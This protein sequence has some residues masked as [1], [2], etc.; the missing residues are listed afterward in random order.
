[1][2]SRIDNRGQFSIIAAL[3]V[4]IVLIGTLIAVYAMIRY[5]SSQNQSPQTLTATDE[6][7]LAI[8]KALGFTVGYYGSMLQVTGNQTYAEANA[9]AYMN[10]A[11]RYIESMNPSWG[12]SISMTSLDLRTD[13]FTNP[14]ISEG[15]ISVSYDLA[16]LGIYGINYT[17]SCSLAVQIFK[18]P[19]NNQVC[20]NVTQDSN[21]PLTS[22]GQQNFAFYEYNYVTSNWQLVNPS[23]TPIIFTNGTYLINTPPGIENSA[24]MVQVTDSR[25]IMVEA[26]S[27]NSFNLNFAFGSQSI[28]Q[29]SPIIVQLLQNGT[30]QTF[31]QDLVNTTQILPIPPIPVKSINLCQTGATTD[32]PFQ[33]EDWSSGYMIPLG[34]T[35]CYTIFSN[36]QM[37]VFEVTPSTSQLTLWWNGS[38]T[39]IQPSAAYTDKYFTGDNPGAGTLSNG[40]VTLNVYYG[41]G[42]FDIQTIAGSVTSTA[43]F[44]RINKDASNYGSGP[45][46]IIQYGV[47]RDIVQEEAEWSGGISGCPNVYS[48]IVITLPANANYFTYQLRTIFISSTIAR[49]VTDL[50]P[51]QLATTATQVQPMTENGT[52][53]GIPIVSSSYAYFTNSTGNAHQ[54]SEL[55]NSGLQGAGI[56]FTSSENQQ[57]YAFDS[58]TNP[59]AYTGALYVTN[60]PTIE[61]DP[62]T[63][64]GSASFTSAKDITWYG[65]VATFNG[66]NPIYATTGNSGLWSLVAQPPTVTF[67]PETAWIGVSTPDAP[68]GFPVTVTGGG[69]IPNSVITIKFNGQT[70][71]TTKA[72]GYGTIPSG[73]TFLTPSLPFGSYTISAHDTSSDA[74]V[75]SLTLIP[76]PTE[77][78]TFQSGGVGSDAGSNTILTIDSVAYTYSTLPKS[79][80]WL[81]GS[82]HTISASSIISAGSSKQYAWVSWS[83]TGAQTHNYTVPLS[84]AT[85]TANYNTQYQVTFNYQVSG[86]GPGYSA[87]SVSYYQSG[88]Q[89]SITAGQSAAAWVDSGSTYTYTNNPLQ[90][91]GSSERWSAS[92][93]ASGTVSSSTTFDPT[94]YNQYYVTFGY[95]D[96]DSST[97]TSGSQIG[98]YYQYGSSSTFNSGSSYGA[99]SPVSAWVDAGSAVSY[100]TF[101]SGSSRWALSS[102]PATFPVSSST[103]ISDTNFYHQYQA[104]ASYSISDSSTPSSSI[105]LSGTQFGSSSYTLTLTKSAQK[106]WLDAATSW[107]VTNPITSG[108]ERWD[109]S[110]GTSGTMTGT[111]TIAPSYYDQYQFTLAY[112]V[113][114]GGTGYSAPTLTATQFGVSYKPTLGTT[115]TQYWLDS[116]TSWSITNPL[117]GSGSSQ[118]WQ[119][120]QTA[121]GTVSSSS[122]T[123][124][125]NSLTFAFYNQYK[126]TFSQSGITNSAGSNTVLT[127]GS[128]NYAYNALPNGVWFNNATT[129]TWTSPVSGG[130]GLQF[131]FSSSTGS[132][133]ISA[134][135]T[136]SATYTPQ[137]YLT[138]T[139]SYGSPTGAGWYNSG[140]SAPFSVTTPASGGTG[141]QYAFTSWTGSGG[142][143][144]GGSSS[145]HSVTMNNAITETAS[146]QTQY[147]VTFTQ[148]GITSAAGSNTVLTVGS[149]NYAWNAM[150]S[151]VWVNSGTTF[152]WTSPVSGGTGV[153]FALSSSS[154]TSPIT[155]AETYTA[156][157]TTQYKVTFTQ[158]GITSAAGSNTVLTVGSTNYAYNAL[159]SN[160]WVNSGTA[161]TWAS[162]VSGGANVQFVFSTN[163]GSSPV[164]ASGTYTATYAT[165]YKVTFSQTGI[166][167]A[168][169]S[170][171]VL[172]VGSTNYAYNALPNGIWVNSGTTF[173]WASPVS[174]GTGVQ[175]IESSS[176]G[177]SPISASG[178]YSA[179]YTT[180]CY[181]TVTSTY[182]S[183]TGQGWYNAGASATFSVTTPASGGTGTQYVLI[184]WTGSGSG[185]YTGSTSSKSVTMNNAINETASWQTQYYLTVTSSYGSPT[186]QG[187]YNAGSSASFSVTTPASG[188]TGVQYVFTSWS[189][190]GSGSYSGSGS[191]QSV[192]MNNAVTETASWQTQYYLTVTSS[193]GSP[194]GAGWYNSG[195]S[196]TFS[197]TTPASGGTGIQYAFT[198]WTGSGTGA[199][200]GSTN[201]NS[202]TMNNAITETA[203]WQTQY[204]VTFTQSGITSAAGSNT[205]L[206]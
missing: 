117:S 107:S 74:A 70:V 139:S 165:Q 55:I 103:T 83:D 80:N 152:T 136:Y 100:Q 67:M 89:L 178:T 101:T 174:G 150:P 59:H 138:V 119:T 79:F 42:V 81:A 121:S 122:P 195:T 184:T 167:S 170:N 3:L 137:Y 10:N 49:T 201:P 197:V 35:N 43:N 4:V 114:G 26:S 21:E 128:T 51:L 53:N 46:Y 37:I 63:S 36:S 154:G 75:A 65:A 32:I 125:G 160:L 62:V 191:S 88:S 144:Y 140:T 6:T 189:G 176:S 15:Q 148:T 106:T 179:T 104:T 98:S 169:G 93:G 14:S 23:M 91:S 153:Q 27:Y 47:V 73:T 64:A 84:T 19:N 166:T 77:T 48:Q 99:T 40:A 151:S 72:T 109:A 180:Q 198:S 127:V 123:T 20:L 159:P 177:S 38:D 85:V 16:N 155:A 187:W 193:Y 95:G 44:M 133:P 116:G 141:I 124:A 97:I 5:D 68:V 146:W 112:S 24:F 162:P 108:S 28:T 105:V 76:T 7:N 142:G 82:T 134:A 185:A 45:A 156:T 192:T 202:V 147:Q 203:N 186:G 206:T 181:L 31:G 126:V 120:S 204:Q 164:T 66:A 56:M 2:K 90:G 52:S 69:F 8:L 168:A 145:S 78:V 158:T 143:S 39:A 30:M 87:P 29:N 50:S 172:T 11:L 188:G 22:L 12:E 200:T 54:W 86:G 115:G 61:L 111:A 60:T 1:M 129:F 194:T 102:S 34:L 132:S 41:N 205:V 71:N 25:G 131:T 57:L 199:Y 110:S 17:T 92:T 130:T 190:S 196:A 182:G 171:T 58:M 157:Y 18:S 9:T 113:T 161:F 33:V 118:R 96:Q 94:F 175:F 163:S 135:Q 149:T 183:P 173:T 13:W